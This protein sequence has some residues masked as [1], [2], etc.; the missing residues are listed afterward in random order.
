MREKVL[1]L[2]ALALGALVRGPFWIEALRTPVDGDTAIIGL[3][4][5]H[6]GRGVTMWGQPYGSPVEAWV[7]APFFA[8]LGASA[9]TLRAVYFV[10]GLALI[11]AAWALGRA[12]DPRAA[13]P[14]AFLVA[15]PAPYL[16]LMAALP[17]PMYPAALLL[18]AVVLTLAMRGGERGRPSATLLVGTGIAAGLAVWTHLMTLPAVAAAG[19]FLAVRTHNRRRLWI[20]ALPLLLVSAPLWMSASGDRQA[21]APVSLSGRRASFGEHLRATLP[22][23]HR[24]VGGILG[25]HVPLVA[26]DPDHAVRAPRLVAA[27]IIALWLS[28]LALA[29]AGARAHPATW[30][31]IAVVVATIAVFPLP[32]R[33]GPGTIRFLTPLY[34]PLAALVAWGAVARAGARRA[35]VLVLALAALHLAAAA[36][37]LRAWRGADRAAA[38]FLLPDLA[39]VRGVLEARGIRRAYASY[40]PAYR[41]TFETGERVIAS[42]PWNERF[43]HFPLPYLDEVRFARDVAWILFPGIPSDLPDVK[44]F[45]DALAAAGGTWQ[46][47]T[48]G[49]ATVYTR[50]EPPFAPAVE[51]LGSAGAAGDGDPETHLDPEPDEPVRFD[52]PAPSA[53]AAVT[54]VAAGHG[55]ALP[56]S[57]DLEV[58]ADGTTFERVASRRRRGERGDLRWV[59]GHPQFVIDNDVLPV[60]LAGRTVRAIRITPVSSTDAWSLSEVLLHPAGRGADWADWLGPDLDWSARREAL[61]ASPRRD[62]VDWY[63]RWVLVHRRR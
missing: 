3:M 32:L 46:R 29:L 44:A 2:L 23:L 53:L 16:L 36:P 17:P 33:S 38:P 41:L 18:S 30:P 9:A 61:E 50:F 34:L 8:V 48:A 27:G 40:G 45:E 25:T 60:S 62:R 58:S 19:A 59:N 31:L 11:P 56:R 12:L 37:L 47:E 13:L 5:R 7:A 10:L 49:A 22:A 14:A 43:L 63:T 21:T 55:P 26:D 39:R 1:L 20:A 28:G 54:L 51:P 35:W 57:M 15:C 52:L 4:A 42:Q 6:L 24:P